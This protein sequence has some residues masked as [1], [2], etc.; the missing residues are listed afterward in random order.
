METMTTT[1]LVGVLGT[2]DQPR[3]LDVR[4]RE[5]H[6][7]WHI[8]GSTNIPLDEL[9]ARLGELDPAA[10]LVVYCASGGRSAAATDHLARLGFAVTNLAGGMSAWAGTYDA[11]AASA[12]SATVVQ[13][14]R[15]AKGCLSYVVGSGDEAYVVDPSNALDLYVGQAQAHG[16]RIVGVLDTHLHADH[17]SGAR[18]LAG[19]TGATLYLNGAD[20]FRFDFTALEDGQEL[21]LAG[22]GSILVTARRTPGHTEGSTIFTIGDRFVLTG[23]TLFVDGVGRPDL[24]SKA[25]AFARQLHA[26]L[27]ERVLT[28]PDEAL[29]LPAHVS[30]TVEIRPGELAGATLETLRAA[31]PELGLGLEAFVA[32]AASQSTP[33]PPNYERIV[34]VNMGELAASAG[35]VTLLEEGPNRCALASA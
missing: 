1:E 35:D 16:W 6:R 5:E 34:R 4:S 25:E 26:S 18:A 32:H 27:H 7:A 2:A 24:A 20:A 23:D 13:L 21:P 22:G 29:V 14:R 33:R 12:G 3:L 31:L 19:A 15:R 28:L 9:V 8:A 11:V 10:P 30:E 17:V